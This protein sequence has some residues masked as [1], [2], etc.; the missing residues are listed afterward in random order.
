MDEHHRQ[1][2][3]P[4]IALMHEGLLAKG[5]APFRTTAARDP[6]PW[7]SAPPQARSRPCHAGGR[8]FT[9]PPLCQLKQL[10][11]P[12][13]GSAAIEDE[14]LWGRVGRLGGSGRAGA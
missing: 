6:L 11:A 9:S 5:T 13:A 3:P 7:A 4:L 12:V 2:L 8:E 10:L 14:Q 1:R